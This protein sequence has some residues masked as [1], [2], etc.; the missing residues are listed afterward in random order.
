MR[1][2]VT[3]GKAGRGYALPRLQTKYSP[4]VSSLILGVIWGL[5]HLPLH[6]I[7]GTTQVN[8]P[9]FEYLAQT[10]LLSVVYAWLFNGTGRVFVAILFH[11]VGNITAAVFPYWVTSTGRWV[12]FIILLISVILI[13]VV[14]GSQFHNNKVTELES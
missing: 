10:I 3:F 4:L 13:V 7:E 9:I 5:W 1:A 14:K 8:I 2:F 11:F 6:F 12:S